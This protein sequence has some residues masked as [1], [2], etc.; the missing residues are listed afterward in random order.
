MDLVIVPHP[1]YHWQI[2]DSDGKSGEQYS[3]RPMSLREA[4]KIKRDALALL[5]RML[6]DER[7]KDD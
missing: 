1:K 7:K 6:E 2:L 4:K 3:D 5:E